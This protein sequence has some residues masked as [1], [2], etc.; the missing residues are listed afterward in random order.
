MKCLQPLP[1]KI[2]ENK[3]ITLFLKLFL[4]ELYGFSERNKT[5]YLEAVLF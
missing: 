2:T 4:P 3:H 1:W 5:F